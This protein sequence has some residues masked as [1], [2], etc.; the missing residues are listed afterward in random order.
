LGVIYI[1]LYRSNFLLLGGLRNQDCFD[2]YRWGWEKWLTLRL[3]KKMSEYLLLGFSPE[4]VIWWVGKYK[5]KQLC[6]RCARLLLGHLQLAS[7]PYAT[8][9]FG[10]LGYQRQNSQCNCFCIILVNLIR[11]NELISSSTRE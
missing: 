6:A 10:W 3:W 2:M 5:I 1:K 11:K 4:R 8:F 9:T 7:M